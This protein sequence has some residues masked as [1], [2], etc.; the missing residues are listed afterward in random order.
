MWDWF[1]CVS[2]MGCFGDIGLGHCWLGLFYYWVGMVEGER[3]MTT[4]L[5][6]GV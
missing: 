4:G 5:M 1:D 3:W 6:F 2:E